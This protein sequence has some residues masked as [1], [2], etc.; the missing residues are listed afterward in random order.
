MELMGSDL[1][2]M[3]LMG[4]RSG[5]RGKR[6]PGMREASVATPA[7]TQAA[8]RAPAGTPVSRPDRPPTGTQAVDR[9]ARLVTE[10]VHAPDSVT[11]TELA[12]ATGLAKSTTSRLLVALERG[13][14]VRRDDDGRFR[15]GDV[16]VR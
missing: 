10:V 5:Q 12:A 11:F 2:S 15:P 14:L 7:G 8:D 4:G 3:E 16:F 9:A 13:G 6:P 1:T